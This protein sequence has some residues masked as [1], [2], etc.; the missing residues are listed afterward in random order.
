MI[1][2][3]A[4]QNC[5]ADEEYHLKKELGNLTRRAESARINSRN[6]SRKSFSTHKIIIT[7]KPKIDLFWKEF[8][9][10]TPTKLQSQYDSY[11]QKSENTHKKS[12]ERCKSAFYRGMLNEEQT[13]NRLQKK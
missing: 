13:F 3:I 8:D 10:K 11:Q 7:S 1:R 2:K 9:R 12:L 6:T 5:N 4:T